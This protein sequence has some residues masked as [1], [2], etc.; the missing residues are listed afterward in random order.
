MTTAKKSP[1]SGLAAIVK[2]PT[3]QASAEAADL[4]LTPQPVKTNKERGKSSNPDY[5]RMTVYVRK[6]TRRDA[7]RKFEDG[8]G[9]DESDLVQDLLAAYL[10]NA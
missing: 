7:K 6:D 10:L 4:T 9:R 5:E 3:P 1:L 8:G 2:Q